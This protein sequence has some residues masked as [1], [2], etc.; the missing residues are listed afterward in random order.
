[1]GWRDICHI[2]PLGVPPKIQ[3]ITAGIHEPGDGKRHES[4][5]GHW[6][7]H[8]YSYR[9]AV[10]IN[11]ERFPIRPGYA[12]LIPPKSK[13]QY[14]FQGRS[15]H[16]Y[17]HFMPVADSGT[18]VEIPAMQDLG[19]RFMPLSDRFHEAIRFFRTHP[20]R[21]EARLLDLLWEL[22][23]PPTK[24]TSESVPDAAPFT[25]KEACHLIDQLLWRRLTV[26]FLADHVGLSSDHL[27]RLFR[28][29]LDTTV[30]EY[31]RKRRVLR[32]QHL[33]VH[34][35]LPIKTVA[36]QVGIPDLQHF[37]KTIRK[38]LGASPRKIRAHAAR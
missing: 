9:A 11:G 26:P 34:S 13:V 4:M 28:K 5:P 8:I 20:Q 30:V 14:E 18:P 27:T 38:E 7:F 12:G 16:L 17:A 19:P 37:S 32:A 6:Y 29:N 35:W 2:L 22:A 15:T 25:V 31:I 3:R 1:M 23:V 24:E 33:L 10:E 36:Q 21:A